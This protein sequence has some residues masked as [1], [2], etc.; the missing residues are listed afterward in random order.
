MNR[1]LIAVPLLAALTAAATP[2]AE[3]F[4]P[5][6]VF[7][8]EWASDPRISPDGEG[9]AYVRNYMDVMTDR[10]CSDIWLVGKD[11]RPLVVGD[12]C[13]GSPRWSPDGK[14]LLFTTD[15]E[16]GAQIWMRW[17]DSGQ[18]APITRLTESPGDLAW[19]P[20]GRWVAFTMMV[21]GRAEPM[22]EPPPKPEGAEWAEPPKV[23][24]KVIYRADGRGYLEDGFRHLFL[25]PAEGGTPRQ[26]TTGEFHHGSTPAWAPDSRSLLISANR[27]EEWEYEP[28]DR[29]IYEITLADGSMRALTDRRGPD[30]SP[31][32]SPNGTLVAYTGFDDRRQGYQ[33]TRLYVMNRDG[34]GSK[35]LTAGFDR[36]V[37]S[38]VWAA[39]GKGIYF[40]TSS[41]GNGKI[42][43]AGLDG[44]VEILAGDLGGV[45]LGRPYA[46]G[47]FTVQKHGRY[48]YT[49]T[50]PD[51]PADVATGDSVHGGGQRVTRLN[52]D[53]LAHRDLAE[54]E[55]I[56]FDSSHDGRQIQGWVAKPPG[57][58]PGKRYPT[59]LE[60]HGGPFADYGDRWAA[61]V[62]LYAAAG[63]LV[64][65]LNPRG[66]TG[67]GEEFGNLIHHDY[68]GH[69]YEDLMSG[70]DEVIARGWADP[71]RLYVTG[72]SGGGV[73]TA[74][75]VGKT[76]RFRAAVSA[77]PVINWYSFALTA[78]AYNRFY[79]Y[80]FP[81]PPWEKPE[82]YL[83]RSPLSLVG[84]VKTPTML[85]TGE[86][87]YRTPMS[88][89]EQY[90]Q[91]L[92]LR[93]VP[94]ALVR[95]PG[96][97]HG[98]ARRPSQLI[99][100]VQHVLA[101]FERWSPRAGPE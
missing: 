61:E 20:D 76:D 75:I 83:A 26:V 32:V 47:S 79:K 74:W 51:H 33:V 43:F 49:H 1:K 4:Q 5:S 88:E 98:I 31:A 52:Q 50:R 16:G 17:M 8:L 6:D 81:A 94:T 25:L 72:G 12:G 64:L 87:D 9:V 35:L 91:A 59:I 40:R 14:R 34:S 10:R 18:T 66:S 68:P 3:P 2:A 58:T 15:R 57:F 89:S 90:Y 56:W 97:S 62:Q 45:S 100:K 84:N 30:D 7:Q 78:D 92:K 48:A 24:E 41:E 73:L 99:A 53:L 95:V 60:I 28:L 44:N 70:V 46:S 19:S 27:H 21:P 80:W 63:Y 29:E 85:L 54:V 55:E 36:D 42:A 22:V 69:D 37:R 67:Y 65:Y 39:D 77:K 38:P 82:A 93:R 101:W 71:G 11:H 23:I 96:A 13:H 86:E